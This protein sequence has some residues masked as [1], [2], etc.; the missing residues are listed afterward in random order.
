MIATNDAAI[1]ILAQKSLLSSQL[2][3]ESFYLLAHYSYLFV[4]LFVRDLV[5]SIYMHI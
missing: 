4:C 1:A 3:Y 2:L 5:R